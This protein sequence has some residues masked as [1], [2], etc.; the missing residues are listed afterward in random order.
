MGLLYA[1][2]IAG[3]VSVFCPYAWVLY[4]HF[5]FVAARPCQHCSYLSVH[6]CCNCSIPV[7]LWFSSPA[8]VCF[9]AINRNSSHHYSDDAGVKTTTVAL[10]SWFNKSL[11]FAIIM[12]RA[13]S[14]KCAPF[15]CQKLEDWLL[16]LAKNRGG[17]HHL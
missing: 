12:N 16:Q 11:A 10:F 14:P 4:E 6:F 8:D 5:S 17:F 2:H 15:H 1:C 7:T 9:L 13:L 3:T